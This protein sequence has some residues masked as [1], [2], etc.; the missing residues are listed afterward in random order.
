MRPMVGDTEET[1]DQRRHPRTGPHLADTAKGFSPV[2]QPSLQFDELVRRHARFRA[3]WRLPVQTFHAAVT[4]SCEA[5]AHGTGADSKRTGNVLLFPALLL[6]FP[7]ADAAAFA[8]VYWC[9]TVL[10]GH[11]SSISQDEVRI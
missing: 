3:R 4:S 2:G 10:L 1:L 6:Q 11:A 8:P 9:R 5:L 7:R